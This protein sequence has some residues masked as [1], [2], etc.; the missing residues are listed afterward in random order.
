M[1]S[2]TVRAA[3]V[4]LQPGH[5][6]WTPGFRSAAAFLPAPPLPPKLV[7]KRLREMASQPFTCVQV[8]TFAR[9]STRTHENGKACRRTLPA[10]AVQSGA[11]VRSSKKSRGAGSEPWFT[12]VQQKSS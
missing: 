3:A 5:E 8:L 2:R 10:G 4:K 11:K 7:W 12:R 9:A 1:G 6:D